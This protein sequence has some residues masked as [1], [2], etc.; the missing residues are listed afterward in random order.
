MNYG[1]LSL[2][3]VAFGFVLSQAS[4]QA[5]ATKGLGEDPFPNSCIALS[6]LWYADDGEKY[7]IQQSGCKRLVIHREVDGYEYTVDVTPGA[8][9]PK[10]VRGRDWI[11][12]E[13]YRW[14]PGKSADSLL[15]SR[16]YT[17]PDSRV[18]DD[19]KI[20]KVGNDRLRELHS[21]RVTDKSGETRQMIRERT[22]YR[23]GG[24][25]QT[26]RSFRR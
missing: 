11:L 5:G 4:A 23:H 9:K 16:L 21:I 15:A 20:Q 19:L 2:W 17:Y 8:S 7:Y 22:L 25:D 18:Q 3:L 6:G 26:G 24:W 1:K 14:A 10:V 12:V 13:S